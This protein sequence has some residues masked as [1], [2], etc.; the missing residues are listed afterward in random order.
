MSLKSQH[1]LIK[2]AKIPCHFFATNFLAASPS[3]H[4]LYILWVAGRKIKNSLFY[5]LGTHLSGKVSFV[6]MVINVNLFAQ[7]LKPMTRI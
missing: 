5:P 6:I 7:N 1:G 3:G 4:N 2:P